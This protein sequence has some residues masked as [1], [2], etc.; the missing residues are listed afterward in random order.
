MPDDTPYRGLVART[1]TAPCTGKEMR[2]Y[3]MRGLSDDS[4]VAAHRKCIK[5]TAHACPSEGNGGKTGQTC[6]RPIVI[7]HRTLM[8]ITQPCPRVEGQPLSY[9][10]E[11][12]TLTC[13]D[14]A[15]P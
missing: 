14:L 3:V 6:R 12:D 11:E 15:C 8:L 2:D 10:M 4:P 5:G 13:H 7:R 1:R 9:K